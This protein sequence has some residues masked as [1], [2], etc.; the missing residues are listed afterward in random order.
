ME[1]GHVIG[2]GEGP[3]QDHVLALGGGAHRVLGAEDDLP[4]RGSG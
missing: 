4:L 2:L 3:N 1:A